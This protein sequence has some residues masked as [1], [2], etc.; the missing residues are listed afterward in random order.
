MAEIS[1]YCEYVFNSLQREFEPDEEEAKLI[2]KLNVKY[3][4]LN[5]FY[6]YVYNKIILTDCYFGS[7]LFTKEVILRGYIKDALVKEDE[8]QS[9]FSRSYISFLRLDHH[10]YILREKINEMIEYFIKDIVIFKFSHIN[11]I[12]LL[13]QFKKIHNKKKTV[14]YLQYNL[15]IPKDIIRYKIFEYL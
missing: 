12:R 5:N 6:R 11:Y 13:R 8:E 10:E 14:G 9:E 1:L 4:Y 3:P 7:F 15:K 2:T